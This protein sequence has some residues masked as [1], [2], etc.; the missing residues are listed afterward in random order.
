[1]SKRFGWKNK[2]NW[3]INAGNCRFERVNKWFAPHKWVIELK[4][5]WLER[6]LGNK[7]KRIRP[8]EVRC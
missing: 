2:V 3:R 5:Q 8:I 7:W 4:S 1:M 6:A